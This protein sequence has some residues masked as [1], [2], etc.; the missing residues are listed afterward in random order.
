MKIALITPAPAQ[1]R[2]G[3]RNTA[4][5]W[6]RLMREAGHRIS[7]DTVWG[8][9]ASDV[10]IALHARRSHESIARFAACYPQRP[11][12]VALTGTDLYRDIRS[13]RDAQQS[14][15]LATALVVLQDRGIRELAPALRRKTRVIYQSVKPVAP[16]APVTRGFE[17]CVAGHLRDEKDP[18]RA[19]AALRHLPPESTARV[20]HLGRAL[21]TAMAGEAHR[22]MAREPRYVWLGER[23]HWQTLRRLARARIMVISSRMEG[24]ANVVGEALAA[25]VPVIASRIPGTIGMLGGDYAGYFPVTDER[26]LARLLWRAETD[27]AYYRLLKR[28]C[29]ARKPL[30]SPTRERAALRKLLADVR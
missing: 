19:A 10:L 11:L 13:D 24:G 28:Q 6:A 29:R 9:A 7:V 8:G 25:G 2:S 17:I 15:R 22:W 18:F 1:S 23:P 26:A 4:L 16:Q 5:R 21:D 27:A 3:N 30:V 20:I 14:L 12:I